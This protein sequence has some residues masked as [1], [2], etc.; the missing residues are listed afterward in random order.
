MHSTERK[1]DGTFAAGDGVEE[2]TWEL[3]L[4]DESMGIFFWEEMSVIGVE[5]RKFW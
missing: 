3:E 1:V 5:G 2:E 4:N